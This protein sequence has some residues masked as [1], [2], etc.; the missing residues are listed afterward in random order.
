MYFQD[1]SG[2]GEVR[3]LRGSWV[4]NLDKGDALFVRVAV[5]HTLENVVD[6]FDSCTVL[7]QATS[8]LVTISLHDSPSWT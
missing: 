3:F 5:S 6:G 8:L 2:S 1:R 4:R 7:S